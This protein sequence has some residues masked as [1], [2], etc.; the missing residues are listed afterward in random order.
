M[1]RD[2]KP[3]TYHL[4]NSYIAA[5]CLF[6]YR[7][8]SQ[9][10][11]DPDG[12]LRKV[13]DEIDEKLALPAFYRSCFRYLEMSAK[14]YLIPYRYP[15]STE[16]KTDVPFRFKDGYALKLNYCVRIDSQTL[17]AILPDSLDKRYTKEDI[18]HIRAAVNRF[19]TL[20]GT[21]IVI[22]SPHRFSDWCVH[23][24][25]RDELLHLVAMERLRF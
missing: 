5:W 2:K 6:I 7:R 16:L 4:T 15:S 20:Y 13:M 18:Q 24:A 3:V 12:L 1:L 14:E 11:A 25:G 17:I 21:D 9:Q 22:F 23:E 10:I 8:R 19:D